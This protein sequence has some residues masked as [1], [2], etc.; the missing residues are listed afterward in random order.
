MTAEIVRQK[1]LELRQEY[2]TVRFYGW[3]DGS[4]VI[5]DHEG[6]LYLEADDDC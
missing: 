2:P 4:V 1:L 5:Q 3:D 6:V